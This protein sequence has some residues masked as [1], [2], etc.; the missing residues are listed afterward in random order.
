MIS[1]LGP[2][3]REL[4]PSGMLP[5]QVMTPCSPGRVGRGGLHHLSDRILGYRVFSL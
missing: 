3:A 5:L 1:S 4:L 2:L